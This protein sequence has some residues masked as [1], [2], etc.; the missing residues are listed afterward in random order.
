[1]IAALEAA[2][3]RG[4]G[5]AL[6]SWV[7]GSGAGLPIEYPGATEGFGVDL[8]PDATGRL[9]DSLFAAGS[10]PVVQGYFETPG[11]RAGPPGR[12]CWPTIVT[13]GWEGPVAMPTKHP[14]E[15]LGPPTPDDLPL[16][17][18]AW[19]IVAEP[20][21]MYGVAWWLGDGYY[22]LLDRFVAEGYSTYFV[23]R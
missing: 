14:A 5:S 3:A 11:C 8:D 12:P 19:E 16:G 13:T 17:A 18:A 6:G 22:E 4:S 9:L 10:A 21:G 15:S 1:V 7:D 23:I 2:L 20:G